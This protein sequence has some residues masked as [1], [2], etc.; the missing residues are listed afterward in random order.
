MS[1]RELLEVVRG[2]DAVNLVG[3]DVVEVSPAY[4]HAEI[5]AIAAANVAWEFLSVFGR[6]VQR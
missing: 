6:K 4:D 1:S 3:V 5:T 2:L